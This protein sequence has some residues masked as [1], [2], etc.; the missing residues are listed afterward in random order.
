MPEPKVF[1]LFMGSKNSVAPANAGAHVQAVLLPSS[2]G[3]H[4]WQL[5]GNSS[6]SGV[7]RAFAVSGRL[8]LAAWR[9]VIAR[10]R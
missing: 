5:A 10:P 6:V 3:N 4:L 1:P 2:S 7:V 9:A 8:A